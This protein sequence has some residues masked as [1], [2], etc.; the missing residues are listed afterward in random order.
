MLPSDRFHRRRKYLKLVGAGVAAGPLAGCLGDDDGDDDTDDGTDG[1]SDSDDGDT[2]GDTDEDDG[3][4]DDGDGEPV[5][6]GAAIPFSGNVGTYGPFAEAGL[7]FAAAEINDDGGVLDGREFVVETEDNES[8]PEPTASAF[9]RLADEGAVAI[10]GPV[11]SDTTIRAREEAEDLEVPLLPIQGSSPSVLTRDTRY[12]FR[13]GAAG[14]P[15]YAGAVSELIEEEG[16]E[17]YGAIFAE[18]SYGFS[19]QQGIE[20][21]ILP[22]EGLDTTVESAPIG[23]DDFASQLR[24]M[25][26]DVEYMDINGHPVGIHTIIQQMWELDLEPQYASGPGDPFPLFHDALGEDIDR[27]ILQI[28]APDPTADDYVEVAERYY[29][30]TGEYFDPFTAIGYVI[31]KQVAAAVEEAGEADPVAVRDAISDMRFETIL[32]YPLEYTE[33]GELTEVRLAALAFNG[34]SPSFYPDAPYGVDVLNVSDP[35]DPLDP[36]EWE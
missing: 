1:D 17:T 14:A 7:Q 28:H 27:G 31:G 35:F 16:I 32:P 18:Y 13:V 36:D 8:A 23:A 11:L 22:M 34:E 2:D 10:T 9:Q 12:V 6:I 29:E 21:F 30:E 20:E 24:A 3:T 26:D 4:G 15:Y 5:I 19:Y 25:P 33:W